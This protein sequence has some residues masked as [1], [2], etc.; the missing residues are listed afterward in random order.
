MVYLGKLGNSASLGPT[1]LYRM[2]CVGPCPIGGRR[3]RLCAIALLGDG[4]E[5]S[6]LCIEEE[7]V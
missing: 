7:G 5:Q 6:V 2:L 1:G 3:R 4:R